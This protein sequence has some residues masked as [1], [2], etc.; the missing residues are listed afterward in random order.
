MKVFSFRDFLIRAFLRQIQS[1]LA[2]IIT[3]SLTTFFLV[4]FLSFSNNLSRGW[5][6]GYIQSGGSPLTLSVNS[7]VVAHKIKKTIKELDPFSR[8]EAKH[9]VQGAFFFS[10]TQDYYPVYIS[11]KSASDL[12][13]RYPLL[14]ISGRIFSPNA[15]VVEVLIPR[16]LARE[17]HIGLHQALVLFIKTADSS[18]LPYRVTVSGIYETPIQKIVK[19]SRNIWMS[20]SRLISMADLTC[21]E[22][23]YA[24]F[25]SSKAKQTYVLDQLYHRFQGMFTL[26]TVSDTPLISGLNQFFGIFCAIMTVAVIMVVATA[27]INAQILRFL[28]RKKEFGIYLCLGATSHQIVGQLILEG[29]LEVAA[30][31]CLGLGAAA[32][33]IAFFNATLISSP[34]VQ[35]YF[36]SLDYFRFAAG[37]MIRVGLFI[38][39]TYFMASLFCLIKILRL[40]PIEVVRQC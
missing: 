7:S 9:G 28:K 23:S 6:H 25:F 31:L 2:L 3:L 37:E 15:S 11:G 10:K 13:T 18:L 20:D 39:A 8:I 4:I 40:S 24:L 29:A 16:F 35:T 5:V 14:H 34:L 30:S 21:E 26:M 12:Q 1:R 32:I 38:T 36:L 22:S 19:D 33:V 17:K 27:T